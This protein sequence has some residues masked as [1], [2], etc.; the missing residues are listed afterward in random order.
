MLSLVLVPHP[1]NPWLNQCNSVEEDVTL[2]GHPQAPC[3]S[4]PPHC[5]TIQLV[6]LP[7]LPLK[8]TA[9]GLQLP[10]GGLARTPSSETEVVCRLSANCLPF[11]GHRRLFY[12]HKS[13]TEFSATR[14][15]LAQRTFKRRGV[16]K[17]ALP[18]SASSKE[19][20]LTSFVAAATF[21]FT[22]RSCQ[23]IILWNQ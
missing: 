21:L 15:G 3:L 6:P 2:E 18:S 14:L 5:V 12:N 23:T 4:P 16:C 8:R 10:R 17:K 11:V 9:V 20:K 22:V 1:P 19:W 13:R 7:A